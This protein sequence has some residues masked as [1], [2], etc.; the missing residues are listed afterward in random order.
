M[1]SEHVPNESLIDIKYVASID[2]LL[3]LKEL[4]DVILNAR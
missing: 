1:T 4:I 2:D 3:S